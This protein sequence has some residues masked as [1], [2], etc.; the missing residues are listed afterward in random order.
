M[1]TVI[2]ERTFDRIR[3][4]LKQNAVDDR[5]NCSAARS[6][7]DELKVPYCE[8]GLAANELKIKIKN[9]ELGCF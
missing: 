2:E 4:M 3:E 7:A 9:C 5:V 6:I 8:V 1:K